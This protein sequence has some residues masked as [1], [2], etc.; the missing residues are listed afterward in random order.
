[1]N[2]RY[3][4]KSRPEILW[5]LFLSVR[6]LLGRSLCYSHASR[7]TGVWVAVVFFFALKQEQQACI[8]L[9]GN[10][11]MLQKLSPAPSSGVLLELIWLQPLTSPILHLGHPRVIVGLA[12]MERAESDWQA[13]V[14]LGCPRCHPEEIRASQRSLPTSP[15]TK[16]WTIT[17]NF[18]E[19]Q[20]PDRKT[21]NKNNRIWFT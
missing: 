17:L 11:G 21:P 12:S 8:Y 7:R 15:R 20:A 16:P 13:N 18:M 2:L 9:P 19:C 10:W 14:T 3:N 6:C 4:L 1:M 5:S